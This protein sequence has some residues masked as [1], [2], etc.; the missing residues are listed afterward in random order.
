[1]GSDKHVIGFD[2]GRAGR[3]GSAGKA[4]SLDVAGEVRGAILTKE[5]GTE[6][7]QASILSAIYGAEEQCTAL[8]HH[9][10]AATKDRADGLRKICLRDHRSSD[11][12]QSDHDGWKF[13]ASSHLASGLW[14]GGHL[15]SGLWTGGH[16]ATYS[17]RAAILQT[18]S[19]LAA[20]WSENSDTVVIL[21]DD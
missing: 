1:M 17:D 3:H 6:E 19:G 20:I 9:K 21:V 12:Q 11:H 2:A 13:W 15:A 7:S 18:G 16:L 10:A 4:G 5:P 14:P 8:K